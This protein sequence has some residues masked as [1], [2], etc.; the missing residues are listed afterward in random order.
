ML[1][2]RTCHERLRQF[3][4]ETPISYLTRLRMQRAKQLL[5]Q[6]AITVRQVAHAVGYQ[7]PYYFSKVFKRYF[8][9][10]PTLIER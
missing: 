3:K 4:A 9:A 10:A 2:R 8:G 1:V 6:E 7:D 5:M